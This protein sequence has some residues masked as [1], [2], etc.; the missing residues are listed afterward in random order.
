MSLME[1]FGL[2]PVSRKSGSKNEVRV[3]RSEGNMTVITVK[4]ADGPTTPVKR[5]LANCANKFGV[6][7]GI[8]EVEGVYT[9]LCEKDNE[10]EEVK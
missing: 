10:N 3:I 6:V 4:L 2:Q 5:R 7:V 8:K 1:E 9:R